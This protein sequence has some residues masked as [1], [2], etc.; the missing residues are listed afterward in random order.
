[1]T[2][3]PD[4]PTPSRLREVAERMLAFTCEPATLTLHADRITE[5]QAAMVNAH[6]EL[7]ALLTPEVVL[8]L[9]DAADRGAEDG[10]RLD[11]PFTFR[12]VTS[13]LPLTMTGRDRLMCAH[14]TDVLV[15]VRV[16]ADLSS[17]GEAKWRD[18]GVDACIAPLVRAL[19]EGGI[20]MR[21]SC[22]GHGAGLGRI[23]LADGRTLLIEAS[24]AADA[25][26]PANAVSGVSVHPAMCNVCGAS[27][28]Q[29]DRLDRCLGRACPYCGEGVIQEV[30]D[31]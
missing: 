16:P 6:N 28:D 27:S 9:L 23:D 20:D 24:R 21:A 30:S 3:T 19:Q 18:I 7:V 10:A 15:R 4:T 14:G 29:D 5:E 22:C 13:D 17:T 8:A 31:D 11:K 25:V 26:D 2:P 1:M 12:T